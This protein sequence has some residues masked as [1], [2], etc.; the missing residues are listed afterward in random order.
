MISHEQNEHLTRIEG[1]APMGAL[2]RE[3]SW[4]P[5]C[6]SFQLQ[7]DGPPR[8]VRLLGNDYVAFRDTEGR[9]GFL[10]EACPHRG[11]SLALARNERCALTCILH[12][13]RIDTTGQ[14]IEAATHTPNPKA[15]AAKIRARS[16]P[17]VDAGGLIWVYL[18]AGEAPCFPHLPFT[19]LPERH[20]WIT[21]TPS[22]CNWLQGVEATLDTAHIGTLHKSYITAVAGSNDANTIGQTLEVLA[23]RYEVEHTPYGIDAIGLRPLPD[24]GTYVRRTRWILPFVSLVPGNPGKSD[25]VIFIV[26]PVDDHNHVLFFGH[27]RLDNEVHDGRYKRVPEDHATIVGDQPFDVENFGGFTGGR[28]ENWGQDREAM[29]NGHFSGFTGNLLQEDTV[30]QISMGPMVDRT[31]EHLSSIDVAIIQARH[32]LLQALDNVEQGRVPVGDALPRDLSD[33]HPIDE[34]RPPKRAVADAGV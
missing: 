10:D 12:G 7:V 9:V 18:G 32:V 23:P 15:F 22:P 19:D 3:Y 29:N 1:D 31:R 5:A 17:V 30:T 20:V 24:G 25:G 21:A 4:I 16:H 28:D 34:I 27:W 2:M 33:L 13:W 26:S 8:R 14:V 6:L 11:A